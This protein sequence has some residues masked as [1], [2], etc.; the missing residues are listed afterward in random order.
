MGSM[1]RPET[2]V[3]LVE[4]M[5]LVASNLDLP[6]AA[7]FEGDAE[8]QKFFECLRWCTILASTTRTHFA[9][10]HVKRIV[11]KNLRSL[12]RHC[13]SSDVFLA[14]AARLLVLNHAAG[15][16][17]FVQRPIAKATL[18]ILEELVESNMSANTSSTILCDYI[19][20]VVLRLLDKPQR[21]KWVS[22]LV[23][24]LM[25][26]DD[27][28]KSTVVCRLRM[29]WLADDDPIR[30]Y[31][32]ALHQLQLFAESNLEWGYDGYDVKL[33]TQCSCS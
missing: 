28:P 33:L 32:A 31:A 1:D 17:P 3:A 6:I 15:G 27:F 25:D 26:N 8:Q 30:T 2:I 22:L 18:G 23:K 16:L 14:D 21:Q 19:L 24:L 20:G 13:R 29:L 10:S 12:L 5:K 9:E 7:W 11:G 4:Q